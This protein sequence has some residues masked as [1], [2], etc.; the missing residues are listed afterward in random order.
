[1]LQTLVDM[2]LFGKLIVGVAISVNRPIQ[3]LKGHE[4][5][6]QLIIGVKKCSKPLLRFNVLDLSMLARALTALLSTHIAQDFSTQ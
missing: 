5:R 1:M 6:D 2:L 3:L 4:S